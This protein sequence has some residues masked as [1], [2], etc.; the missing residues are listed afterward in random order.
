VGK[1]K[2]KKKKERKKERK[3]RAFAVTIGVCVLQCRR[4]NMQSVG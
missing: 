3:N 4:S 1:W 2:K